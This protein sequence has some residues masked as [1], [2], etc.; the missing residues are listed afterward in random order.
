MSIYGKILFLLI[1]ID[2]VATALGLHL[3]LIKEANPLMIHI[4]DLGGIVGFL[5]IKIIFSLACIAGLEII[6]KR[7]LIPIKKFGVS[8][9]YYKVT[10]SSYCMLYVIGILL[11]NL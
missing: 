10:I 2:A 5:V 8:Y 7:E 11:V 9:F 4:L 3:N 6:Y 1:A